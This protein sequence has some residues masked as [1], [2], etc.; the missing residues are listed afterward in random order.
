MIGYD[1]TFLWEKPSP[2]KEL[3]SVL[4]ILKEPCEYAGVLEASVVFIGVIN[5]YALA[6]I[7]RGL[8]GH[9]QRSK[10]KDAAHH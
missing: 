10:R 7:E 8:I 2:L 5:A 4:L 3:I 6:E 1:F 9:V